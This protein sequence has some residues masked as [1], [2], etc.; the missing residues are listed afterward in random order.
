MYLYKE[1]KMV[2]IQKTI[3]KILLMQAKNN[4]T[5]VSSATSGPANHFAPKEFP[6]ELFDLRTIKRKMF[7]L[8]AGRC[9]FLQINKEYKNYRNVM[10]AWRDGQASARWIL[11][12]GGKFILR[13]YILSNLIY[14]QALP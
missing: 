3:C 4:M 7:C 2:F 8:H 13:R 11:H 10:P 9:S 5:K 1:K 6:K 14:H 12:I